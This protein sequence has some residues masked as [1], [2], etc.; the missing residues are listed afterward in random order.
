METRPIKELLIIVRD[1]L[2]E[3]M[4]NDPSN[5]GMCAVIYDLERAHLLTDDEREELLNYLKT[6]VPKCA[7]KY[8]DEHR[9]EC[10]NMGFALGR[11]WFEPR[12]IPPRLRWLNKQINSL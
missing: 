3:R 4:K 7:K 12:S 2:E 9:F 11:H 8:M 6:H 10:D 5:G 1:N